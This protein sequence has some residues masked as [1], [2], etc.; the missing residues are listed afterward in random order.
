M[1][2]KYYVGEKP[3]HKKLQY[4][5]LVVFTVFLLGSLVSLGVS[6]FTLYDLGSLILVLF[7]LGFA[8]GVVAGVLSVF[9]P[10]PLYQWGAKR[11]LAWL[12]FNRPEKDLRPIVVYSGVADTCIIYY[13]YSGSRIRIN[14]HWNLKE[15]LR[16]AVY[17]INEEGTKGER[18]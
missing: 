16:D 18:K 1:D 15:A 13:G 14:E 2:K 8:S 12:Y 11:C 9:D 10:L 6:I 17:K 4:T 5:L 3:K 7:I